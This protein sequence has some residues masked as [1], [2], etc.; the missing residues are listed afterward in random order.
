MAHHDNPGEMAIRTKTH[1]LIYFY[2]CDYNGD[3]QTPPAW[4]L[5]DLVADPNE[6][7][8]LYGHPSYR[9]L[10]TELKDKLQKLRL[11]IGDDGS[12]YPACE[13]VIQE[14]WD[15]NQEDEKKAIQL[16][17]EFKKRRESLL[18]DQ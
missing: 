3:N 12:H 4:E 2:G 6:L 9:D 14:F 1:K 17:A 8:N 11:Q 13:R 18:V 7:H 16:S 10:Q 5:Y 15:Y